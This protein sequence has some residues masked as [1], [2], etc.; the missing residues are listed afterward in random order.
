MEN[1]TLALATEE[2]REAIW[3]VWHACAH[4]LTSGQQWAR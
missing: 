2:N 3:A 4:R 1:L